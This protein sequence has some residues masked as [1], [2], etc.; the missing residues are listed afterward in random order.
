MPL[1]MNWTYGLWEKTNLTTN[2]KFPCVVMNF[3]WSE[4]FGKVLLNIIAWS[5]PPIE[6]SR[7]SL[8][9]LEV[10]WFEEEQQQTE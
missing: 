10:R 6:L 3:N 7:F 1:E 2:L 8:I 4:V 9:T 5:Q